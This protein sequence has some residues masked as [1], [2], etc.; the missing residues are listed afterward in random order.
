M[1][2]RCHF[3]ENIRKS[4]QR[5]FQKKQ[6]Q[7]PSNVA[8]LRIEF[9]DRYHSFKLLLSANNRALEIMADIEKALAGSGPFGMSFVRS[10]CTV[11]IR[12]RV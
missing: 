7:E 11:G 12:Q 6:S 9:K 2:R 10:S 3:M 4:I 8:A 1:T 5:L